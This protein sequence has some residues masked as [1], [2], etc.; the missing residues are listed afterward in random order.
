MSARKT[1]FTLPNGEV[2]YETVRSAGPGGCVVEV[3][4]AQ[5]QPVCMNGSGGRRPWDGVNVKQEVV[6]D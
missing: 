3:T 4:D 2:Y 6:H 1:K 5:H